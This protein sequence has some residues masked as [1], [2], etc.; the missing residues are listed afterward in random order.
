MKY[1]GVNVIKYL[2]DMYIENYKILLRKIENLNKWRFQE[3]EKLILNFM[4]KCKKP[5]VA[6][7]IWKKKKVERLT[8]WFQDLI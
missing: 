1:L 2:Q 5:R 8:L 4:W 7:T 6:K 3:I